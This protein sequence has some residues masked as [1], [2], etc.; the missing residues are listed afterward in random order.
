MTTGKFCVQS[1]DFY[2]LPIQNERLVQLD[3]QF[4]ELMIEESP[5][6]RSGAFDSVEE[7]I[8]HHDSEFLDI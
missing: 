7:A 2:N 1:A 5:I 6:V 3:K 8:A 4:L